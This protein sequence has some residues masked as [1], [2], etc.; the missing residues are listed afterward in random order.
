M[1]VPS[2]R[3]S[4]ALACIVATGC[5]SQADRYFPVFNARAPLVISSAKE[6]VLVDG[7]YKPREICRV[8]SQESVDEIYKYLLNKFKDSWERLVL[9]NVSPDYNV[10]LSTT[11]MTIS[12]SGLTIQVSR[13]HYLFANTQNGMITFSRRITP[14]ES[15]R[16]LDRICL[17]N[18]ENESD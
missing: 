1:I 5:T 16:L 17:M 14:A 3:I 18:D 15:A 6:V 4:V 11:R 13:P 12:S 2:F 7:T 10:I 8:E 9:R